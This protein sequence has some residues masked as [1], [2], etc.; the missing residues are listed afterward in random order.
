MVRVIVS[1]EKDIM[2]IERI[3]KTSYER[4]DRIVEKE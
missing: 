2:R 3:S 4:F 1:T